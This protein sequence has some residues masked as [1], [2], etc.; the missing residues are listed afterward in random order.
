MT[1]ETFLTLPTPALSSHS[2]STSM[3]WESETHV[4]E[5]LGWMPPNEQANRGEDDHSIED[6]HAP[7][8]VRGIS[9]STKR[10]IDHSIDGTNLE[11][12]H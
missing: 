7:F 9:G 1:Y 8:M 10:E 12:N 6:I 11:P 3:L 2:L 4:W 5:I